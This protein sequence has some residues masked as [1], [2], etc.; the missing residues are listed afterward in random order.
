MVKTLFHEV[1]YFSAIKNH[2][3]ITCAPVLQNDKS[4]CSSCVRPD[5]GSCY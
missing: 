3:A 2:F 1:M 5:V 4:E